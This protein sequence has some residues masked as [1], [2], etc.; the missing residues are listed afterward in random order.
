MLKVAL[1]ARTIHWSKPHS[2][3]LGVQ[4]LRARSQESSFFQVT[5]D[6]S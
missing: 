3:S 5:L 4:L 6:S 2:T 1:P